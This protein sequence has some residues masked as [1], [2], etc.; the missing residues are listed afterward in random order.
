M[1]PLVIGELVAG[2]PVHGFESY[3]DALSFMDVSGEDSGIIVTRGAANGALVAG[4]I[5][6]DATVYAWKQNDELKNGK[7]AGDE[8]LKNVAEKLGCRKCFGRRHRINSRT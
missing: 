3:F 8:W 6:P 1:P 2:D 4:F 5:P 7:R